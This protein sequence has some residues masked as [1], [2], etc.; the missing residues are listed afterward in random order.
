MSYRES[1]DGVDKNWT[2]TYVKMNAKEVTK[3]KCQVLD[4]FLVF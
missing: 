1:V 3:E 4:E 2:A